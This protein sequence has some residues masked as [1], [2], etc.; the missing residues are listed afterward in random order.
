MTELFKTAI[1][2]EKTIYP[3]N[4]SNVCSFVLTFYLFYICLL[5]L[6]SGQLYPFIWNSN[7][8][9]LT[10]IWNSNIAEYLFTHLYR[11]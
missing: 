2:V 1:W 6:F 11:S 4:E 3:I 5:K 7:I 8:S 10:F 9:V